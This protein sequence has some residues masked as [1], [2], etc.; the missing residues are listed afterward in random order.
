MHRL[1]ESGCITVNFQIRSTL[2]KM[3]HSI[4][5]HVF[6]LPGLS[7]VKPFINALRHAHWAEQSSKSQKYSPTNMRGSS[8]LRPGETD[9]AS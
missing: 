4:N 2:P 9:N 5:H 8:W 1:K 7:A 6:Q 3:R